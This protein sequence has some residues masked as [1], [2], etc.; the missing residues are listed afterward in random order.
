MNK[1]DKK[2]EEASQVEQEQE[3]TATESFALSV[4]KLLSSADNPLQS[5]D[6]MERIDG[7]EMG[8]TCVTLN[9]LR[10]WGMVRVIPKKDRVPPRV[11]PILYEITNYGQCKV[12]EWSARLEKGEQS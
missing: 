2:K 10:K 9:K 8:Q 5:T 11:R 4:L 7:A 3:E 12:R 6:V 1:K